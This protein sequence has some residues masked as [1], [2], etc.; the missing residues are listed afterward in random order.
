MAKRDYYEVLGV[1]RNASLEEIKSAYRKLAMKYHPDR[2]PGNKEAEE[3]FKEATEAYEVL[4]DPDKRERY[5]RFGHEGLRSG[6]DYHT[7]TTIDDIFSAFNDIFSGLG[8]SIFDDFF[9]TGQRTRR[10][11]N[12]T[13]GE[14]GSDLKIRL[15][16]T[17]EEIATGV[18][19]TIKLKKFVSCPDC[20]GSGAKTGTGYKICSNCNGTG[21]IRQ[22]SRSFFG[23]FINISTCPSCSGS[24]RVIADKCNT[25]NGEGRINGEET[26]VV[27]IPAG[28]ENGNY[29]PLQGKGNAGKRG[30][31]PGDLIIVIE[32]KKHEYFERI[33]NDVYY[34]L[35]ISFPEAVL[36]TKVNVPTLYGEETIKIEPGTQPGTKIKLSGKGIPHLNQYG[37]GDQIVVVNIYVPTNISSKEKSIL[38]ELLQSE[39]IK[40]KNQNSRTK[41]FFSKVRDVFS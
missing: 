9:G 14:R 2:N 16:L 39:N 10:T 18:E 5:D 25:C 31:E 7:Y 15:P 4:S 20:K 21:E 3:K 22:V 35:L 13:I 41:D 24:G 11:R 27:K 29:L 6:Y 32:E 23:Q 19:K 30:G 33:R 26:V 36:G 34:N 17:L 40:P 28:V 37:K 8:S 12:V 38:K 1:S